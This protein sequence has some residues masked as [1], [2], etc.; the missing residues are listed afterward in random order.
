[1]GPQVQKPI[2]GHRFEWPLKTGFIVH[3]KKEVI[4]ESEQVFTL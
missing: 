3:Q 1:M 2:F 4:K